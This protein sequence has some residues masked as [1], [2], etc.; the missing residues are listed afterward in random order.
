MNKVKSE[1]CAV[2]SSYVFSSAATTTLRICRDKCNNANQWNCHRKIIFVFFL[3]IDK[4][5][6]T[7]FCICSRRTKN[8]NRLICGNRIF[9][10]IPA[11][12]LYLSPNLRFTAQVGNPDH[13]TQITV[14][15]VVDSNSTSLRMTSH[16]SQNSV[17]PH[18]TLY[19][20][21]V[22]VRLSVFLVD[23]FYFVV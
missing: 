18:L 1:V 9:T 8:I 11:K 17:S 12:P 21:V 23:L 4:C 16:W 15:W 13:D 6:V 20:Q 19:S 2:P 3:K 14:C 22:F 5:V 10:F 7:A